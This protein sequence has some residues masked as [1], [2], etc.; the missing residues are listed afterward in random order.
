MCD[1]SDPSDP[2]VLNVTTLPG[3]GLVKCANL[4]TP[5]GE[6]ITLVCVKLVDNCLFC[7]NPK[8]NVYLKYVC[9]ELKKGYYSCDNCKDIM[10]AQIINWHNNHAYGDAKHLKDLVIKI[11][12]SNGDIQDNYK[13]I[14]PVVLSNKIFCSNTFISRWCDID[15]IIFLNPS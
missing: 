3:I 2:S 11:K 15:E 7:Q 5:I 1:S 4:E 14:S 6:P 13:I 9:I 12:R 8:G 10:H